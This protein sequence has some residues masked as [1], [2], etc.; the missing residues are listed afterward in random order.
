[1]IFDS[2]Q[3]FRA[4]DSFIHRTNKLAQ[5]RGNGE[6]KKHVGTYAGDGGK[7]ISHFFD[8]SSWGKPHFDKTKKRKTIE[9]A[10]EN[11][12]LIQNGTCFFSRSNLLKYLD[13]A[14]AEYYAKE[15]I[16]HEDIS[17]YF[18]E[19]YEQVKSLSS[20]H[21]YFSIYD[22]SDNLTERQN[23]GYIRSDD[24][25]WRL[26]RLLILPKISYLS[27][28]KLIPIG[29]SVETS[30]P[31]FYFRILLDYQFR[32]FIHPSSFVESEK[33]A[34]EIVD[35][36]E[37]IKKYRLG[38]EKY[39]REVLEHMAQC[40]F[41]LITDERLLIASHIKPYS[42][43]M[44]DK[45]DDQALDYLNGLTLSPTY[46]KLFDQGYITFTNSGA[47]I[48][49]TQLS[50]LTWQKLNINPNA[51]NKLRIFPEYREEYL[52]YHRQHVFQDDIK[53]LL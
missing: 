39:R 44:K 12:A 6:A 3:D 25:I 22:A 24:N 8:Y 20:D 50:A 47:L 1:M 43:C 37:S 17:K 53:D 27:I 36:K 28:L 41:T 51:K 42:I 48:C 21:I 34:E 5:F 4:E 10:K 15:Q 18:E 35:G 40:P 45:R 9:S 38:Q 33:V 30:K 14:K 7:K 52:E 16:Y 19:R 23:R 11:G 32:S 26:W 31:L 49:G 46:D 13:D 29:D 2:I